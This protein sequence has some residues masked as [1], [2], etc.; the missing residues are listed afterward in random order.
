MK[1][2]RDNYLRDNQNIF[3]VILRPLLLARAIAPNHRRVVKKMD[4]STTARG[5]IVGR[6]VK[7]VLTDQ[8]AS[9]DN[10]GR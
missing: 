4:H 6:S 5:M 9:Q 3:F 2:R 10:F 1:D 7:N 8:P